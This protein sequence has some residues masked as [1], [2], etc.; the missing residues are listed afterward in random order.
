M[1][2]RSKF[3]FVNLEG[4]LNMGDILVIN[5]WFCTTYNREFNIYV[6]YIIF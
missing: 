3:S 5:V 1:V 6:G 4:N 2:I